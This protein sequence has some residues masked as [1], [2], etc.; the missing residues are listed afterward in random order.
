MVLSPPA[1]MFGGFLFSQRI[2]FFISKI[3]GA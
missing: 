2:I 1:A 3:K